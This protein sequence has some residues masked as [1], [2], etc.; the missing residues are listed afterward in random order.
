MNERTKKLKQIKLI[1]KIVEMQTINFLTSIT[2][3]DIN[4]DTYDKNN[5]SNLKRQ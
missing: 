4:A 3:V 1:R 2:M 5:K